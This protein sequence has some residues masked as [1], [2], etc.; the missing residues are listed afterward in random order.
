M[1]GFLPGM[2]AED[3][4]RREIQQGQIRDDRTGVKEGKWNWQDAFGGLLGGYTQ[5]DVEKIAQTQ[6]DEKLKKEVD[7]LYG[8]TGTELGGLGLNKSYTGSVTGLTETEVNNL[9]QGDKSKLTAAI[10]YLN[11]DGADASDLQPDSTATGIVQAGTSK[12]ASNKIS[13]ELRPEL[14][15]YL[16]A[17]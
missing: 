6:L 11:I 1:L 13:A 7:K 12:R 4:A 3:A 10:N 5:E 9:M 15:R 2:S 16:S 8:T 17:S 14:C